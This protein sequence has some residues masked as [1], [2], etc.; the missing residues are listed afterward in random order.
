MFESILNHLELQGSHRTDNLAAVERRGKELCH[1]LVHELI[2][3]LGELLE[4]QRI[5]IFDVTELLGGKRRDT[6]KFQLLTLGKG[7]ANL[8]VSRIVQT[9]D[10]AREGLVDHRL[11]LSHKGRRRG[12]LQLLTRAHMQVILIAL[13]AARDDL[14]K[15]DAVAVV[16]VHVGMDLKDETGHLLLHGV[17][18]T[19]LGRC[20]SRRG[21]DADEALQ[22]LPDTEVIDSRAKEYR[23]EFTPQ[24]SLAVKLLIDT[25]DQLHILTQL[26]GIA[27]PDAFVELGAREVLDLDGRGIGRESFVGGEEREVLLVKVIHPLEGGAVRD[28]KGQ[29]ANMDFKL[30]LH[31]VQEVKGLFRGAVELVDKDNHGG[32][33][34]AA[35]LHQAARLRLDTLR[36]VDDDNHRIDRRQ[37]TVGILGKVLVTGRI[38]DIDLRALILETHHRGGHRDTALALDLHKVRGGSLLDFI[39]FHGTRHMDCTTKQQQLLG[40]GRLTGIGVG[41]DGKGASSCNLFL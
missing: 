12:E 6:R 37:R 39:A 13:E 1:T 2:D 21:G 22:Q 34:H 18:R 5:G 23:R 20:G 40:K 29:R 31:L 30:V 36:A 15:G 38:E 24:V 9:D 8:E 27:L 17:H 26:V 41:N 19:R 11:L 4:F 35:H 32:I 16:G 28:R 7:V 14:H 3:P 10:I 25:L 33:A